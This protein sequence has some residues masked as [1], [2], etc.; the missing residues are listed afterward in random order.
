MS[1]KLSEIKK[2]YLSKCALPVDRGGFVVA[3][4]DHTYYSLSAEL[5]WQWIEQQI[6]GAEE[7]TTS[8]VKQDEQSNL[9]FT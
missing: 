7:R 6:R 2:E 5:V 4:R 1:S 9:H 8:Q 3:S